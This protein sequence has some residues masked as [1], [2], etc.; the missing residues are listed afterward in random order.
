[1]GEWIVFSTN[2]AGT[3]GYAHEVGPLSHTIHKKYLKQIIDLNVRD[4]TIKHLEDSTRL[5]LNDPELGSGFLNMA[6]K[7]QAI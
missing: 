3:N 7:V 4:K 2:N 1:M 6:P 5:S